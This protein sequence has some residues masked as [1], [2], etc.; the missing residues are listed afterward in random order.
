[1][2]SLFDIWPAITDF[3]LKHPDVVIATLALGVS[4]ATVIL[5]T[6][7]Q[8]RTIDIHETNSKHQRLIEVFSLNN[9]HN[10]REARN[11]LSNIG[12]LSKEFCTIVCPI[13]L[14]LYSIPPIFFV[15]TTIQIENIF[16]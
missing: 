4:I 5:T 11:A 12:L 15:T 7:I 10:N 8:K 3:W 6:R 9:N 13:P 14:I 2:P 16:Y 1:M